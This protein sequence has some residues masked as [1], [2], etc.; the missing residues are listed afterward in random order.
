MVYR[1]PS[2]LKPLYRAI[3]IRIYPTQEQ[4]QKLSQVMGGLDG[5]GTML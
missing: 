5:G 2:S 3:K 4:S 1:K